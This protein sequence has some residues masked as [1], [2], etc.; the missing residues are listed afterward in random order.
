MSTAALAHPDQALAPRRAPARR[1][2]PS[3]T[4]SISRPHGRPE[5][6]ASRTRLRIAPRRQRAARLVVV[7]VALL[8]LSMIGA[9][10]LHTRLAE[11]QVRIDDYD[12]R[13]AE[14]QARFDLLRQQ[15]AELRA[16]ERLAPAAGALGMFSSPHSQFVTIDPAVLAR[17]IAAAGTLGGPAGSITD[18]PLDQFREVKAVMDAGS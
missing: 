7:F 1:P 8:V 5:H 12:H 18:E 10:M 6:H 17:S 13:V 9:V 2:V 4:T 14:A 11:R 16:P 15:R 3:R